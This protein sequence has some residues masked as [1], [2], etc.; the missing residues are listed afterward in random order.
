MENM[1]ALLKDTLWARDDKWTVLE[2]Q[3]GSS[4]SSLDSPFR[5]AWPGGAVLVTEGAL[6]AP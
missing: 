2:S 3:V 1:L 5:S 6:G 4:S